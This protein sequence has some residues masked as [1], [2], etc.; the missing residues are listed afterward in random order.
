[1]L[2]FS[3]VS[4]SI[5]QAFIWF[6]KNHINFTEQQEISFN[7]DHVY[8]LLSR[9]ILNADPTSIALISDSD[10]IKIN[11]IGA[12][13]FK[14]STLYKANDCPNPSSSSSQS[15]PIALLKN[16]N[17]NGNSSFFSWSSL[18]SYLQINYSFSVN[19]ENKMCCETHRTIFSSLKK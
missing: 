18:P 7:I 2:F 13:Y 17:L 9:D 11:G 8:D 12:Y 6:Q 5:W 15:P 16:I 1:M 4:A 14:S 19:I 10:C 3:I